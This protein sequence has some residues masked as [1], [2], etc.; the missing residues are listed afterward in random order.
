MLVRPF[1]ISMPYSLYV[2]QS[3]IKETYYTGRSDDPERRVIYHNS[4][5]KGYTQRHRPWELVYTHP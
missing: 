5:S 2:L 3:T 1:L 4:E